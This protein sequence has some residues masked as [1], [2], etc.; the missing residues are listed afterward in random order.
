M[1]SGRSLLRGL[2]SDPMLDSPLLPRHFCWTRM[3]AESGQAAETILARK[4][5]ERASSDGTFYWGVGN[6]LGDGPEAV[7]SRERLPQVVFST[8][9]GVANPRDSRPSRV[10]MW[11]SWSGSSG[12][13]LSLPPFVLVTSRAYTQSGLL[14]QTH[15]ALL[16]RSVAS[17]NPVS[18]VELNFCAMRNLRTG[19]PL[20]YSQV[21]A[22]VEMSKGNVAA[23]ATNYA[24]ELVA[25]WQRPFVARLTNPVILA[26]EEISEIDSAGASGSVDRWRRTVRV[27]KRSAFHRLREMAQQSPSIAQLKLPIG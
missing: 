3:G 2:A 27:L 21:T 25:K 4:E 22:V 26:P 9:R 19:R 5:L 10:V 20:G 17:L 24:V 13:S 14:K 1:E 11:L 18:D 16:C 23:R 8:I 7:A 12:R 15:F 6:A